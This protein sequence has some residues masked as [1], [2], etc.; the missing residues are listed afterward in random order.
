MENLIPFVLSSI[1]SGVTGNA[2]YDGVRLLFGSM[3]PSIEAQCRQQ[4]KAQAEELLRETLVS[5]Q[6]LQSDLMNLMKSL[7]GQSQALFQN[8][9][10]INGDINLS[11][12]ATQHIGNIYN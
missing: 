9:Q 2:A 8:S 5:N 10:V 1:A 11:G 4:P 12:N 6:K 3:F 7:S